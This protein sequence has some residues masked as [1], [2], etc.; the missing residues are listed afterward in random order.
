M[1]LQF[2]EASRS[3]FFS[4]NIGL[5]PG[6]AFLEFKLYTNYIM[7]RMGTMRGYVGKG[8]TEISNSHMMQLPSGCIFFESCSQTSV[9][10][11]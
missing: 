7:N 10:V 8:F 1:K 4:V 9:G 2:A 6:A 11:N 3:P 5:G